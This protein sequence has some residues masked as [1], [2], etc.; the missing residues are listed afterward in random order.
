MKNCYGENDFG[1][2]VELYGS[3]TR[4]HNTKIKCYFCR[5]PEIRFSGTTKHSF[6]SYNFLPHNCTMIYASSKLESIPVFFSQ[7]HLG[8]LYNIKYWRIIFINDRNA[9]R[10]GNSKILNFGQFLFY[11]RKYY[12]MRSVE[13][14]VKN[15]LRRLDSVTCVSLAYASL[16]NGNFNAKRSRNSLN[17][18]LFSITAHARAHVRNVMSYCV[19]NLY[20]IIQRCLTARIL[21]RNNTVVTK[22]LK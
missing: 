16:V 11:T 22:R 7:K 20:V 2:L 21:I 15:S 10:V 6:E 18:T 19:Y 9:W 12:L 4:K 17:L 5:L 3:L 13:V 8:S 1:K 14:R